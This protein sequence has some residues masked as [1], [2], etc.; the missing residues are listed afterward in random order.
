MSLINDADVCSSHKAAADA[1]PMP[2]RRRDSV[3]ADTMLVTTRL[4][5]FNT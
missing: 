5:A 4:S 2:S 3:I 1:H